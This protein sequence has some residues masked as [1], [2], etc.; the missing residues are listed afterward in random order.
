MGCKLASLERLLEVL[1]PT[2]ARKRA[3]RDNSELNLSVVRDGDHARITADAIQK[4]GTFRNNG[5]FQLSV[6]QPDQ[7]ISNVPLHQV[8]PGS[9]EVQFPLEQEGSYVFRVTG[10][11]A[12]A[13]RT[14]AYSYPDEYHLHEP[15]VDLLRAI[16]DETKGKFQPD[17]QDIFATNGETTILAMPLW[18]YLAMIALVLYFAD[19]FLRRVRF[20]P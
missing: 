18:P 2:A 8:G 3:P 20:E 15:D 11:K 13:S 16:S 19:I 12:G 7:S 10:E 1:V 14:L 9:Y 5:E 6:V 17:A 4:D